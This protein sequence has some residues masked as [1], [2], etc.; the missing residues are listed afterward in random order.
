MMSIF[1]WLV[2]TVFGLFGILIVIGVAGYQIPFWPQ[3]TKVSN[4]KPFSTYIGQ[5]YRVTNH[6]K[7]LAW[8]DFPDKE[9]ILLVSLTP[10]P[11]TKNRFVS[12][13]I[14]LQPGQKVRILSAWR[15]LSLFE[16]TNYYLVAA[17]NAGLPENVPIK[18]KVGSDGIPSPLFYEPSQYNKALN[19]IG[20][21]QAAAH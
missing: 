20:Q 21:P 19:A 4:E 7:A 9:K 5:E 11:G 16:Y 10:P 1:K 8:N 17:P 12:N 18:M 15:S 14:T 3:D 2:I 13:T 6:I